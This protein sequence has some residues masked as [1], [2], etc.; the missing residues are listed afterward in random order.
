MFV[1]I[2]W[3]VG[4]EN[5][6]IPCCMLFFHSYRT[7]IVVFCAAFFWVSVHNSV[8]YCI[9]VSPSFVGYLNALSLRIPQK[10]F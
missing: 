8:Q 5:K 6:I 10:D 2:C 9:S 1:L 7:V 3:L 4:G